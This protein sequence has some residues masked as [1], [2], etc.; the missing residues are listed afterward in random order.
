MLWQKKRLD[1]RALKGITHK[2]VECD[3]IVLLD[4]VTVTGD[5]KGKKPMA[6]KK[7]S[8]KKCEEFVC[9]EPI[10]EPLFTFC[11]YIYPSF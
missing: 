7:M 4:K 2:S 10:N 5:D 6:L 11:V 1:F 9:Q 8:G 3:V